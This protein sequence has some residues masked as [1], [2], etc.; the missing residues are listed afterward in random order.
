[1]LKIRAPDAQAALT[2]LSRAPVCDDHVRSE[3]VGRLDLSKTDLRRA[4]LSNAQLQKV[5]LNKAR[6]EGADLTEAHLD[7]AILNGA[8]IGRF[9]VTSDLY[10]KGADLSRADLTGAQVEGVIGKREAKTVGTIGLPE[11]W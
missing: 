7:R 6:L 9:D 2:V 1:L 5:D 3:E 11:D 10:R 8:N 4:L